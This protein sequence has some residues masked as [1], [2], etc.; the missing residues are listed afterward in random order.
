MSK[1]KIAFTIWA[2]INLV[3]AAGL[4][5][6]CKKQ[7]P[8]EPVTLIG[9]GSGKID[10]ENLQVVTNTE[11]KARDDFMGEIRASVLK[12]D[13][14]GLETSAE[15]FRTQKSRFESGFWK[16]RCFY[17]AFCNPPEN[18]GWPEWLGKLQQWK[19]QHPDSITPRLALASA[20][21]GYALTARGAD[22]GYKVS[23]EAGR[24]MGERLKASFDC[25][26]E[27]KNLLNQQNDCGFYAL[28]LRDCMWAGVD[29]TSYEKM[30]DAAVRNAPDYNVIY[31]Y[32]AY[33][34]LPRWFGQRGE[35]ESF[36][37]TMAER[38][39]F[40]ESDELFARCAIYLQNLGLFYDEFAYDNESWEALKSSFHAIEKRYPDSLEIKSLDCLLSAE[41]RD[42]NEA[43]DQMKLLHGKID[44]GVWDSKEHFI[45]IARWLNND[46]A[47]LERQ[48]QQ[49]IARYVQD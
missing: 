33:Y 30:F 11:A 42:Y 31:E 6:G 49:F 29:R 20:Y 28:I 26:Q 39:D 16:L 40:P 47:T 24:Q 37:K 12:G 48:R 23:D 41:M 2:L 43:R 15:E 14:Q 8:S 7:S 5:V 13:F 4:I 17:L 25:L 21:C 3:I 46:D 1:F 38:K 19:T 32:K 22:W 10:T 34:L 9:S 44:L 36:A 27:A 45:R 35:W 18:T